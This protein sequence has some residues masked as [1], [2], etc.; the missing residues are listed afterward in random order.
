MPEL[1]STKICSF[2]KSTWL[3]YL[4]HYKLLIIGYQVFLAPAY[5][6]VSFFFQQF[7]IYQ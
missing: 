1:S 6:P 3:D 2:Q 5:Y 4:T 7:L